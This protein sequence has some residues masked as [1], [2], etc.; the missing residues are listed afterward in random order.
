MDVT[1]WL[2]LSAREQRVVSFQSHERG[3]MAVIVGVAVGLGVADG[4][5]WGVGGGGG[6]V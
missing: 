5:N 6:R 2:I 4:V 3:I 1:E